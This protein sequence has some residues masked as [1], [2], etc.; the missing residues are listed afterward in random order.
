MAS[1]R[2]TIHDAIIRSPTDTNM[3]DIEDTMVIEATQTKR[4]QEAKRRSSSSKRKKNAELTTGLR[5]TPKT[6]S[7]G[8]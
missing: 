8:S 7:L 5:D 4:T 2:K 3:K 6:F 1:K